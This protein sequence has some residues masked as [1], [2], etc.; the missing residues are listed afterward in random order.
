MGVTCLRWK[1]WNN[2][3]GSVGRRDEAAVWEHYSNSWVGNPFVG[4]WSS[5][6]EVVTGRTGVSDGCC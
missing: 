3:P 1:R 2:Q 5:D 4:V 6:G